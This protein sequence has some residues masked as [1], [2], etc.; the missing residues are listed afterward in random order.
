L[1][2]WKSTCLKIPDFFFKKSENKN[3]KKKSGFVQNSK[4]VL[5]IRVLHMQ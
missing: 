5:F 2:I 1:G 3:A 4:L